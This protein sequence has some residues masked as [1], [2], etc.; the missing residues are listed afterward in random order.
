MAGV[1]VPSSE[2]SASVYGLYCWISLTNRRRVCTVGTC[3]RR[4]CYGAAGLG[5]TQ[6]D[7]R[8]CGNGTVHVAK[9]AKKLLALGTEGLGN[10]LLSTCWLYATQLSAS[11]QI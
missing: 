10:C 9:M 6:S 11:L 3:V 4:V 5:P 8:E 2:R 7:W 1:P